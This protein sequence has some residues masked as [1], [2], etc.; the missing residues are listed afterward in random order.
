MQQALSE[1]QFDRFLEQAQIML[2]SAGQLGA[3]ALFELSRNATKLRAYEFEYR[4]N[5]VLEEIEKTFNLSLEAYSHYLSHR[6]A[7]LHK[8]S[9]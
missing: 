8:D 4:G 1:N 9:I 6:T 3:F 5:E 2:D 7:S